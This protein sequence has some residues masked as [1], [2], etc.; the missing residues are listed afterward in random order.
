FLTAN[1]IRH[2][3]HEAT[4]AHRAYANQTRIVLNLHGSH[5]VSSCCS[6]Y[7]VKRNVD[8]YT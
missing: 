1:L 2:H 4:I 8:R 5:A 7:E 3:Q 6:S